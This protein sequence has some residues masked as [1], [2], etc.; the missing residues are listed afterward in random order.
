MGI[1]VLILGASGAG[2]STS[3]RNF[4]A[5]EISVFN[6]ACK[7]LPFKGKLPMKNGA[8]YTDIEQTLAKPTKNAYAIDDSQYLSVFD[9]MARAKEVGYGKFVDM[10]IN[11]YNLVQ[12]VI[13]STPPDV[14][15]YFMRHIDIDDS[16]RIKA[17]TIGKMLD[18]NLGGLEGLFSVVLLCGTDGQTHWFETQSDGY[19]SCKS[20]LGMF[21][22]KRIDND[23]KF[24]D[25]AIREFWEL[26]PLVGKAKKD[27]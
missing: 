4:T 3:L 19:T 6:V 15:V 21:E 16:G 27:A 7:P 13:R 1:P 12:T 5:D 14:I 8:T 22:D 2:K 17:K 9:N 10:A 25:K 11:E 24:V 20:P 23:L 18:Q 26:A